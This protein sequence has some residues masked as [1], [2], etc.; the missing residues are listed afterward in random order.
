MLPRFEA[1]M[2]NKASDCV[3]AAEINNRS[4]AYALDGPL[5]G[6]LFFSPGVLAHGTVVMFEIGRP[7]RLRSE[8]CA[9][10]FAGQQLTQDTLTSY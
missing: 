2:F 6:P 7:S 4:Q 5:L 9:L 8:Q 3:K 10:Q 1:W